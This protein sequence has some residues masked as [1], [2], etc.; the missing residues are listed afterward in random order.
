MFRAKRIVP[1]IAML[2]FF[3]SEALAQVPVVGAEE[4]RSWMDGKRKVM[5]VD[6]RLPEEY[7]AGHIPGAVHITA[8]RIRIEAKR[9]PKDRSTPIIFYCRGAG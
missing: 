6:T 2:L 1:A 9:L 3:G 4:V 8:E 5:L 7:E